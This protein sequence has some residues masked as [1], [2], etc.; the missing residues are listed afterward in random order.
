MYT[1][2]LHDF[3]NPTHPQIANALNLVNQR[4]YDRFANDFHQSRGHG[5][6]GWLDL[7][8]LLP[9]RHLEVLDL[10]CGN[11]RLADFLDR[12]W[13]EESNQNLTSFKGVDQ[14][15]SLLDFAQTRELSFP[16]SWSVWSWESLYSVESSSLSQNQFDSA[17]WITL[18]GVMHHIFSYHRRFHLLQWA[19][20]HV[21]PG[22]VLSVSFWDFGAHAKWDK[23]KLDWQDICEKYNINQ[24]YLEP[25]DFLLGWSGQVDTP[26]YCHWISREEEE[27]LNRDLVESLGTGW[28]PP[29][30]TSREGDLN[31]Y[32]SWKRKD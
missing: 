24:Q 16:C 14:C 11:G 21:K 6:K 5:W 8:P 15:K 27:R 32:W 4:F 31:R 20:S 26:R 7:L 28:E 1:H 23:K 18:F 30:M 10:G 9:K 25:G 3:P 2:S 17:D 12:V 13:C 19:L 29:Q 22:G